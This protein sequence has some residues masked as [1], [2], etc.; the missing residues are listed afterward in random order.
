M[1]F[2]NAFFIGF[3]FV[4]SAIFALFVGLKTSYFDYY[5]VNEYFNVIFVDSVPWLLILPISLIFG[6]LVLYTPFR[7][8]MRVIYIVILLTAAAS[9]QQDIGKRVGEALFM[10]PASLKDAKGSELN[11]VE[12]YKARGKI[13]YFDVNSNRSFQRKI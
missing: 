5:G 12:V 11:A 8:I 1:K 3:L 6:Y 10:K 13:Y 9:W 2:V 4:L 7:K